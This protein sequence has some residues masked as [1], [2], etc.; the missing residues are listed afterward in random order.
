MTLYV[1]VF[2]RI[3]LQPNSIWVSSITRQFGI[4][5]NILQMRECGVNTS[6]SLFP[7]PNIP[8]PPP[9]PA[10][11]PP[12][13]PWRFHRYPNLSVGITYRNHPDYMKFF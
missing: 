6:I 11:P 1:V 12:P 5:W 13:P 4:E 8:P 2:Y 7:Q 10:P 3:A 9:A